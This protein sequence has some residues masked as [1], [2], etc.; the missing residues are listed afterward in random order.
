[1]NEHPNGSQPASPQDGA[2]K[3]VDVSTGTAAR[4]LR[5]T[6]MTVIRYI[7]EGKLEG[8]RLHETGH[9]RVTLASVEAMINRRAAAVAA[10][11]PGPP[12]PAKRRLF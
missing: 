7:D 2:R 12:Q 3:L 1:M 10:A 4:M 11:D 6:R 5:V 9:Y 8:H